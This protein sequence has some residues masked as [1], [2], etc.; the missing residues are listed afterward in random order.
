MATTAEWTTRNGV[1]PRVGRACERAA[2][3]GS[4]GRALGGTPS[5]SSCSCREACRRKR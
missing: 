2:P 4:S 1:P 3:P 5:R